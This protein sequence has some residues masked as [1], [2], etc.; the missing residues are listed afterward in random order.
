MRRLLGPNGP[1][2]SWTRTAL[3]AVLV[4]AL[5]QMLLA[6]DG[7]YSP[8]AIRWLFLSSLL[9]LLALAAPPIGALERLGPRA[10][11]AVLLAGLVL[12]FSQVLTHPPGIY[13]RPVGGW[14][15]F[16]AALGAAAVL[17]G[18]LAFAGSAW[19]RVG[20]ALLAVC[21]VAAGLWV[22]HA[23]TRPAI[24]V[25]LFQQ[26]SSDA[27]LHGRNPYSLTFPNIYGHTQFYG[28]EVTDGRTLFFGFPYPPFSLLLAT[29]GFAATGDH[30]SAQ[31]LAMVV[32]SACLVA[33]RPDRL[34][35]LAA[36][37][38]LFTPRSFF[39]LEQGWTEPFGAAL[40]GLVLVSAARA[41][42]LLWLALGALFAW[43]QYTAVLLP[44]TALLLPRPFSWKAWARLMVPALLATLAL[45][46]PLALWDVSAFWRSVVWLQTVQ[47]FR[48]D[49]LSFPSA[50]VAL[51]ATP[52]PVVPTLLVLTA[53]AIA[54]VLWRAPRTPQGFAMSV[55]LVLGV[56]FAFNKQSF[57]NYWFLV[58]AASAL[59]VAAVQPEGTGPEPRFQAEG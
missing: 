59:T 18:S 26:Q 17:G 3:F 14:T 35:A 52:L 47:P 19:A 32:A 58:L 16:L 20:T 54:L 37:A 9:G 42:R 5:G 22:L 4:V 27:L 39:V 29:L 24:D 43:K 51:G 38:L 36:A 57:C 25:F 44:L 6:S 10:P 7:H 2:D 46:L 28:A 30:R 41:P 13:L 53:L 12:Q 50:L 11:L 33:L 21:F 48:A 1:A 15:A 31:L 23:S 34:G 40:L 55:T 49:A 45:T 8:E 56:F